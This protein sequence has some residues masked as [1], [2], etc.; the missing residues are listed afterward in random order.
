MKIYGIKYKNVNHNPLLG[1]IGA[2]IGFDETTNDVGREFGE[3][4]LTPRGYHPNSITQFTLTSSLSFMNFPLLTH[5]RTISPRPIL[6][7]I[8]ENAHSQYFSED[9]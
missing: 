7:I 2:P 5:I 1:E 4:Y 8:G 9:V 3:F 6:L